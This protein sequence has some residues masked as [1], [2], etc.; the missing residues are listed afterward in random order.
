MLFTKF[1]A[2]VISSLPEEG[3]S[4][5]QYQVAE[6]Q[7]QAFLSVMAEVQSLDL[8]S[9]PASFRAK[10]GEYSTSVQK[11]VKEFRENIARY[12]KSM[13]ETSERGL[14]RSAP[15]KVQWALMAA[16]DLALFR[17]SPAAQLDLVKII[18]QSSIL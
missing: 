13:G 12:E 3:A 18:I 7:C 9:V 5:T 1:A 4:K 10:L 6:R 15:R 8:S 14:F 11:F 17:Q 16:E 2:K